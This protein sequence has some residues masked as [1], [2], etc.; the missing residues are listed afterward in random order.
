[1]G[2]AHLQKRKGKDST[3][4][5]T[6]APNTRS[7]DLRID[8]S[9][10]LRTHARTRRCAP[11]MYHSHVRRERAVVCVEHRKYQSCA[12]ITH[13]STTGATSALVSTPSAPHVCRRMIKEP[14]MHRNIFKKL[15][16]KRREGRERESCNHR[17]RYAMHPSHPSSLPSHI[18]LHIRPSYAYL[19]ILTSPH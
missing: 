3:P 19:T 4:T 6:R 17:H 10:T 18:P 12:L 7:G 9:H 13:S 15:I 5:T 2:G 11:N 1:M 8:A 14:N 16:R